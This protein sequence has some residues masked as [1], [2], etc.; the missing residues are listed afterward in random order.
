MSSQPER[1][2]AP[3]GTALLK[4]VEVLEHL[5]NH[6]EPQG[7]SDI[8]RHTGLQ[9]STVFK[10]LETLQ[11]VRFVEK[12]AQSQYRMGVGLVRL[13]H[14]ALDQIDLL[15]IAQPYLAQLNDET[16]ETVHLGV[17]DGNRVVYV[18][19]L[20]SRQAVRMYSSIGKSA[21][22]YCTG[23]G[24]ALLSRYRPEE[25]EEYLESVERVAWTE[26]TVTGKEAL[27][28]EIHRIQVQ[29]YAMDDGEH[30]AD[31]RCVA[32]P[33][34]KGESLY[35]AISVSAP[36]YRFDDAARNRWL[37]LLRDCQAHVL[38]QVSVR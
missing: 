33:L 6:A 13:A 19:K 31:V 26:R 29:G 22:M 23:I 30:E 32:V 36:K 2:K 25:L 12:T 15:S 1:T 28:Q 17:A 38:A 5:A 21:P 37:P 34:G 9:K 8:A 35:G 3:Y 20:E 27:R 4:A 7:V 10:L 24:K 16:G 14:T 11:T 18:A